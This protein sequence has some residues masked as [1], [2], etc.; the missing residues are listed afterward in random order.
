MTAVAHAS[1]IEGCKP[2]DSLPG[3]AVH[4]ETRPDRTLSGDLATVIYCL[5]SPCE[6]SESDNY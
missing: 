2:H 1:C 6:L 3:A 4:W 5:T